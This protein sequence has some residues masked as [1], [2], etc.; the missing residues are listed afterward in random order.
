MEP[1]RRKGSVSKVNTQQR[2]IPRAVNELVGH[3]DR[4]TESKATHRKEVWLG[5][6]NLDFPI[7]NKLPTDLYSFGLK[8]VKSGRGK[9]WKKKQ[10]CLHVRYCLFMSLATSVACITNV[11][12]ITSVLVVVVLLLLL[13][14][15][16]LTVILRFGVSTVAWSLVLD[17][18]LDSTQHLSMHIASHWY[19]TPK[20]WHINPLSHHIPQCHTLPGSPPQELFVLQI[21]W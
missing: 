17:A 20:A 18:S 10:G 9:K 15:H 4:L 8:T 7:M 3:S 6:A 5:K 1:T 13:W 12:Y 11:A 19:I 16:S 21:N 2:K 14:S